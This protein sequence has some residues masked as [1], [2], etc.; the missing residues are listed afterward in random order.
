MAIKVYE[1]CKFKV[2]LDFGS[3]LK[4]LKPSGERIPL[5]STFGEGKLIFDLPQLSTPG[6]YHL[7]GERKMLKFAVNLDSRESDLTKMQEEELKKYL[8]NFSLLTAKDKLK[9]A[10]LSS[11][12]GKEF[13]GAFLLITL[14]LLL[15]ESILARYR[16]Q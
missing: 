2:P 1:D 9:E 7:E 12:I 15:L 16:N 13:C 4:L 10:V 5:R 8:R 6:V 3:N 11:R 14:C